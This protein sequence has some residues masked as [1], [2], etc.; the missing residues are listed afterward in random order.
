[1][2]PRR[3]GAALA[4]LLFLF[5]AF[6]F[7]QPLSPEALAARLD[8]AVSPLFQKDQP[9]GAVIVTQGGKTVYRRAFGLADLAKGTPIRHEMPFRI[10]SV[11]KQFTAVG[12]MLLVDEGRVALSD[13]ITRFLPEYPTHGRRITVENLLA[14]TSGIPSFTDHPQE[15]A[16]MAAEMSLAEVIDLFK[17][18]PL[19][20]EPGERYAYSNSNYV[21]AGAIIEN[22]SG[23]KYADFMAKRIFEPL[24]MR[25]TAFEG[26][27]R[28]GT[29]RVEGYMR[30]RG[31]PF[32]KAL[33]IGMSQAHAA[34]ALIS[35]VDDLARWDAAISAGK[36]LKPESW[37]R[38]FT[39]VMLASGK[40]TNTC[41]GWYL[42]RYSFGREAYGHAGGINGFAAMVYRVPSEELYVAVLLNNRGD[43]ISAVHVAQVIL[44]TVLTGR[45]AAAARPRP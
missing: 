24:G 36:L 3:G 19:R 44:A 17:D 23:M 42:D 45:S 13:D 34:G 40:P 1:M 30:G 33:P 5:C 43:T 21:L 22:V 20:F 26:Y 9:G 10:G 16:E 41:F 39:P 6:A 38:V 29:T 8:A 2:K 32:E 7:A 11:T 14:H 35:T 28:D 18:E 15:P 31:K 4:A 27:E 25:S 12:V 37:Q